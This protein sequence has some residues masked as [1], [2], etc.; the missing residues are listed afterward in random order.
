M[1]GWNSTMNWTTIFFVS[2]LL[3]ACSHRTNIHR[4]RRR[5]HRFG[6]I[7]QMDLF[8]R[9]NEFLIATNFDEWFDE[10]SKRDSKWR[11]HVKWN[12]MV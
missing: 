9:I 6:H 8:M 1:N 5:H 2:L 4:R 10:Y 11:V 12:S 7:K 3:S